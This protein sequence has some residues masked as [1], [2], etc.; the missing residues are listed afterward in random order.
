MLDRF[1]EKF[2]NGL[3][4]GARLVLRGWREPPAVRRVVWDQL[5]YS[6]GDTLTELHDEV[7][8]VDRE[9]VAGVIL[10]AGCGSGGSA[11][12]M[13]AAKA[14]DRELLVFDVFGMPPGPSAKD[15]PDVH[16]RWD[17]IASGRSGGI[18]SRPYY[19]YVDGLLDTIVAAFRRYGLAPERNRIRF[20]KGLVQDTLDG[21]EPV[22]LAHIDCD[23]YESVRTC[24]ERIAPRLAPG[25]VMVVD[26]YDFKSGCK[27]AVDEFL[28]ANP[29]FAMIRRTRVH[30]VRQ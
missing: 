27:L 15:G 28:E 14:P 29:A 24:L 30:I 16:R 10:E 1:R 7:R 3:R 8:R 23:R 17:E 13:A 22:A 2:P 5:S 4:R 21:D 11:L 12:V 20:V 19:G 6:G 26:D 18:G 25:G 9:E